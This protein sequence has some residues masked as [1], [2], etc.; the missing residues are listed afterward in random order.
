MIELLSNFYLTNTYI[1]PQTDSN[2]IVI[3]L[4]DANITQDLVNQVF[5]SW[6]QLKTIV[7]VYNDT[8]SIK[9]FLS[10]F[11]YHICKIKKISEFENILLINGCIFL[12]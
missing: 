8:N 11:T 12:N 5:E 9:Y 1:N 7:I 4:D 6:K 3:F 10:L 2:K